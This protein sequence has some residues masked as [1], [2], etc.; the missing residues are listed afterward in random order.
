MAVS[1]RVV[2]AFASVYGY[3]PEIV[4]RAPGRVNLI[5][6]HTDYND[7]FVLPIAIDRA[8]SLAAAGRDDGM[9][10]L[11]SLDFGQEVSFSLADIAFDEEQRWSNYPRG[12]A[13]VLQRRGYTLRGMDAVVAGDVPIGAGLSS[14]AAIEVAT[15]VAFRALG[16]FD[17]AP[18]D[19]ALA[20][21][22][23]ENT[24]VGMN[25]GIMDQFISALGR[26]GHALMIDCRSL[27]HCAVP[28]PGGCAVL[29]ANTMKQRGLVDSEYN[30]RR[31]ECEDG[32][33]LLQRRLPG[34]R[35]LRDV[36]MAALELHAATLPPTVLRRCRHVV[37]EDARVLAAVKAMQ[38]DDARTFGD[39]MVASHASLRDDY[40]VS[41]AELDFMVEAALGEEGVYGARMT[42]AGF[43]GCTVNLVA[44]ASVAA[45][46]NAIRA[47]YA[48]WSGVTPEL[49]ICRAEDGAEAKRLR[50]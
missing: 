3:A 30:R 5:G 15:A 14:S 36:S 34:I 12:V 7:G 46:A 4:A 22:E 8:V 27:E 32:V 20:A 1:D 42:G 26:R 45:A 43:G 2:S 25:C 13:T 44:T 40:E 18:A 50:P 35:A 29:V 21:Q 28:L 31:S 10:R 49:Y 33:R 24:F 47:K 17:L 48:A 39:M 16:G 11:H 6:E 9:V 41:C 38:Q 23:A 37:G 19:M